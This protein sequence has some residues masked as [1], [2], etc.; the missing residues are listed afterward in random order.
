MFN[1]LLLNMVQGSSIVARS[2]A[3]IGQLVHNEAFLIVM[4]LA[5]ASLTT[6]LIFLTLLCRAELAY[7]CEQTSSPLLLQRDSLTSLPCITKIDVS[8]ITRVKN[9]K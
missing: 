6:L 4:A 5:E 3:I 8:L 2:T 7:T 9:V 1:E